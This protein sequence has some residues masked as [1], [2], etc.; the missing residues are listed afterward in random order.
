M[1]A[2]THIGPA[3]RVWTKPSPGNPLQ[4]RTLSAFVAPARAPHPWVSPAPG[5]PT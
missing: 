3:R 1:E 4:Q 2:D 5:T